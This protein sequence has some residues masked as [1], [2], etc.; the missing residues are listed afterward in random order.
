MDGDKSREIEY[1]ILDILNKNNYKEE[2]CR[3]KKKIYILPLKW[4]KLGICKW[5]HIPNLG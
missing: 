3:R 1:K 2:M 4:Y 5:A